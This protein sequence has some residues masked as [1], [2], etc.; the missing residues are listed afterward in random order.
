MLSMKLLLTP[1]PST[2]ADRLKGFCDVVRQRETTYESEYENMSTVVKH[3][4]SQ[5]DAFHRDD[6]DPFGWPDVEPQAGRSE[7]LS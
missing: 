1:I 5:L 7:V 2:I 6:Q 4:R 3:M